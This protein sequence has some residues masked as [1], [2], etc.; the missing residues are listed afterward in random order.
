[1]SRRRSKSSPSPAKASECGY[2]PSNRSSFRFSVLVLVWYSNSTNF[3]D[4]YSAHVAISPELQVV[5][6]F[7]QV[8]S[9]K[10]CFS[11]RIVCICQYCQFYHIRLFWKYNLILIVII[12]PQTTKT[13]KLCVLLHFF[14]RLYP[15]LKIFL[16]RYI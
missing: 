10:P 13:S 2:N 9:F 16:H 7:T 11:P 14:L 15:N 12:F 6:F 4:L 3:G 5:Q 8:N 1:M